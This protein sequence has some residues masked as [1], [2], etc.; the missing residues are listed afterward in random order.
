MSPKTS[1]ACFRR[2]SRLSGTNGVADEP[3]VADSR[4]SRNILRY[5]LDREFERTDRTISRAES[6]GKMQISILLF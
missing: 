2:T 6:I 4:Y 5:V 3:P 1:G